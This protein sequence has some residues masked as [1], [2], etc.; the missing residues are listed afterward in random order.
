L[1]S[2]GENQKIIF[3]FQK[4]KENFPKIGFLVVVI[5]PIFPKIGFLESHHGEKSDFGK[6][7]DLKK[8]SGKYLLKNYY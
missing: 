4:S 8:G 3:S 2:L 1:R 6:K 7:S 5:N